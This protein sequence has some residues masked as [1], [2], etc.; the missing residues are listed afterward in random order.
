MIIAAIAA[1]FLGIGGGGLSID[2]FKDNVKNTISDKERVEQINEVF[3][4]MEDLM[5]AYVEE[6]ESVGQ[7]IGDLNKDY[8][9]PDSRL[10]DL[11]ANGIKSGN[12]SRGKLLD[13]RFKMRDLMTEEE[14]KGVFAPPKSEESK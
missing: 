3:D 8:D 5:K 13:L 14:W 11:L 9:A 2:D 1:L 6:L 7:Q 12:V 4:E 10:E